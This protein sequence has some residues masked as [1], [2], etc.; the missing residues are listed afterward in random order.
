VICTDLLSY[1]VELAGIDAQVAG[2]A[3][4]RFGQDDAGSAVQQAERLAGAFIHW[5]RPA[6][7]I[8]ANFGQPDIQVQVD[9]ADAAEHGLDLLDRRGSKPD[10]H[11]NLAAR[12]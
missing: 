4:E 12:R 10:A 2:D 5:K 3:T 11:P 8:V 1:G 7:E 9:V 6:Q